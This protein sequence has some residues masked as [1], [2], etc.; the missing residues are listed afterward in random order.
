MCKYLSFD[1]GGTAIKYAVIDKNDNIVESGSRDTQA[2]LGGERVVANV[3]ALIEKYKKEYSLNAVAISTA[4]MVDCKKGE[5]F[6]AG[7]TMPDYSNTEWKSIVEKEYGLYCEVENDVN[8]A[9]LAEFVSGSGKDSKKMLCLTIGTGI[10]GSFVSEGKVYHGA[11]YSSCEVG[12]MRIDESD[13][14]FQEICST[15]TLCKTVA[16][17]KKESV[18]KWNGHKIFEYYRLGDRDCIEA[19]EELCKNLS[20]GIANICY[21]LDPDTV[22]LGGGIMEQKDILKGLILKFLSKYL[23]P[24]MYDKLNVKFAAHGNKAGLLGAYYIVKSLQFG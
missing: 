8:C 9:A 1:I 11:N 3:K 15:L 12:Y 22:V 21:V 2:H 7:E 23:K 20:I 13:K 24:V 5:V 18:N 10:G 16:G 17:K 19:V 4:G 14:N 6:F